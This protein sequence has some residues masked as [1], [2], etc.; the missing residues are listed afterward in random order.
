MTPV[1]PDWFY[2]A[3]FVAFAVHAWWLVRRIE[4]LTKQHI[5]QVRVLVAQRDKAESQLLMFMGFDF[6]LHPKTV[7]RCS[8][9]RGGA[10]VFVHDQPRKSA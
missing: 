9:L 4:R 1:M 7:T 6:Q 10:P 8:L 3:S 5:D 2:P